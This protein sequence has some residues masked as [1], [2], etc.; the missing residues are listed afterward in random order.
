MASSFMIVDLHPDQVAQIRPELDQIRT[1][2]AYLQETPLPEYR[3]QVFDPALV[4]LMLGS[5]AHDTLRALVG[6]RLDYDEVWEPVVDE[7]GREI[8]EG[9]T[10]HQEPLCMEQWGEC[11]C[12][13]NVMSNCR[14]HV[15]CPACG[16]ALGLT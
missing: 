12:G 15:E 9:A 10:F 8:I 5:K 7:Q 14:K 6:T 4:R 1:S 3:G 2:G 16:R 13:A 11:R